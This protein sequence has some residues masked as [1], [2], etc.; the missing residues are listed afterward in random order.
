[1]VHASGLLVNAGGNGVGTASDLDGAD[2]AED[3]DGRRPV[4]LEG[5]VPLP[6]AGLVV[7]VAAALLAEQHLG[8]LRLELVVHTRGIGETRAATSGRSGQ[9]RSA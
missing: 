6:A 9:S 2:G 5:Q 4:I 3:H 1:M 8:A 7:R